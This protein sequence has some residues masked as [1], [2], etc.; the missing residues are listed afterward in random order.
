MINVDLLIQDD[1]GRTLLTWRDDEFFGA[2]W[3]IPGGIIRYKETAADRLRAC[4][5]LEL[6]AEISFDSTPI[7]ISEMIRE[8][9]TRGHCISLLYRCSLVSGLDRAR[10]AKNPPNGGE[11][12]WHHAYPPDLLAVQSHYARFFGGESS[13]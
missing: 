13:R 1:Q 8:Q 3:H 4:A 2:G 5:K 9:E 12:A 6:G 10:Q 7:L 11:W